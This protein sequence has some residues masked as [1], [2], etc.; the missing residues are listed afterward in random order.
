MGRSALLRARQAQEPG[1]RRPAVR[2]YLLINPRSGSG[3]PGVDEL[4]SAARK[5]GVDAH[6]LQESDDAAEFARAAGAALL[7]VAGGDGSL[8]PVAPGSRWTPRQRSSPSRV[9]HG[10]TSP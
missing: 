5:R 1:Y 8:A 3:K 9:G 4:T 7:G 6:V 2:G 10:T